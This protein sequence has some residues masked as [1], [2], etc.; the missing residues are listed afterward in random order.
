MHIYHSFCIG[1]AKVRCVWWTIMN[2]EFKEASELVS[3][4]FSK[5]WYSMLENRCWEIHKIKIFSFSTNTLLWY[6][7]IGAAH[8][9]WCIYLHSNL[10][11]T[12]MNLK[13]LYVTELRTHGEKK[14]SPRLKK[15]KSQWWTG[16]IIKSDSK[17]QI[18]TIAEVAIPHMNQSYTLSI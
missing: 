8:I 17:W 3:V 4:L 16:T 11:L 15:L 6:N 1:V 7:S 10:L 9:C 5:P 2:L 12:H 14:S 13:W 18:E